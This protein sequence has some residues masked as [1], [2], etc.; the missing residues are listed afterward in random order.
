MEKEQP[1]SS[2]ESAKKKRS[3]TSAGKGASTSGKEP[4]RAPDSLILSSSPHIA[5]GESI[6]GLMADVI[7]AM[8]PGI[9]VGI[10][11]FGLPAV[12]VLI[13][14]TLSAVLFEAGTQRMMGR[15]VTV[16]DL[17]AAVTGIL[18]AMN[19]PSGSPWWLCIVGSGIAIVVSK[20]IYGG[21]G[22]NPFNPA[23]VARVVLLISWPV[24][25]TTWPVPKPFFARGMDTITGATPLGTMKESLLLH[26]DLS[27]ISNFSWI[28][29]FLGHVGGSLGEI[30]ALALILGGVYLLIRRVITWHVPVSFLGTVLVIAIVFHRIDP[31]RYASPMFHLV[32][33]GLILGA[34]FMATDLVTSPVTHTGMLIFGAGCGIITMMIRFWGG[35]PEG[36]SFAILLMNAV[37]PLIDR[38]VKP[39]KFGTAMVGTGK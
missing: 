4:E 37:T 20:Q 11:Y 8:I 34:F 38:W 16:T 15:K 21:L 31:T 13:I 17:S 5:G 26:G 25:M 12:R 27:G 22:Y 1:Q 29:P 28:D 19:M 18:L 33:G 2:S 24:Q 14:T 30:S 3:R 36:V 35:Y 7:L 6:R 9:L 39:K 10:Y 23:L 32:T